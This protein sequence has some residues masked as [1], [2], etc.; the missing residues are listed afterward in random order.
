MRNQ[1]ALGNGALTNLSPYNPN[2]DEKC[3]KIVS[4]IDDLFPATYNGILQ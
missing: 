3:K 1:K 2:Q 4:L